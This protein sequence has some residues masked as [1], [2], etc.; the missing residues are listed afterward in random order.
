MTQTLMEGDFCGI[1]SGCSVEPGWVLRSD[2]EWGFFTVHPEQQILN[3][4][5]VAALKESV[6]VSVCLCVFGGC[7]SK[8]F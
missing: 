4:S 5:P 2:S 7:E 8:S 3:E 6:C 1:V